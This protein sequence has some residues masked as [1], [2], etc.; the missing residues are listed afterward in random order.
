MDFQPS[1]PKSRE[2]TALPYPSP[3]WE[4]SS[5]GNR[6]N[7]DLNFNSHPFGL[8]ASCDTGYLVDLIEDQI[9]LYNI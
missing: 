3:E 2:L 9:T 6:G 8:V 4:G 1:R 7:Y 5:R